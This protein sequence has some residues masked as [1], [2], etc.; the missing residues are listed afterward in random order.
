M[1]DEQPQRTAGAI[2]LG[3]GLVQGVTLWLLYEA[4]KAG[5]LVHE[6]RGA[7]QL[8]ALFAPLILIGGLGSI[9]TRTLLIWVA[10]ASVILAGLGVW[11]VARGLEHLYRREMKWPSVEFI[12]AAG[13]SVF[14]A[15]HL[16]EVGYRAR[17]RI[18][19]FAD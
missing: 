5:T 10:I 9:R 4:A 16:V 6:V 18:G 8:L 7:L 14:I 17:R 19:A 12:M 15:H 1:T 2:R 3:I 11:D 13:A